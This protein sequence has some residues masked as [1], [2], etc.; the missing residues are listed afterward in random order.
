VHVQIQT[1]LARPHCTRCL[2]EAFLLVNKSVLFYLLSDIFDSASLGMG[3]GR[4]KVSMPT[5]VCGPGSRPLCSAP[6]FP[7]P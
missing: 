3:G 2:E 5:A 4:L 7:P 1:V 6:G